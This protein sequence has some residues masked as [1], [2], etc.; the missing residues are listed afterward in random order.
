M[1]A[2][3]SM[4]NADPLATLDD[5]LARIAAGDSA[6]LAQMVAQHGDRLRGYIAN[7]LFALTSRAADPDD[8]DDA[9]SVMMED[10]WRK[11]ETYVDKPDISPVGLLF[12]FAR[13]SACKVIQRARR[14]RRREVPFDT[15]F[16]FPEHDARTAAADPEEWGGDV[17][18]VDLVARAVAQLPTEL[19]IAV[20]AVHINGWTVQQ[21]ARW[22]K[23]PEDRV[24]SRL[25]AGRAAIAERLQPY[26]YHW[27]HFDADGVSPDTV[28]ATAD[29]IMTAVMLY[30]GERPKATAED[31]R[32]HV[33]AHL[34]TRL[35]IQQM[36][37]NY[38]RRARAL[39][40]LA[41]AG[42]EAE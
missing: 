19:R 36:R 15:A 25:T 18:F 23:M 42:T 24:R 4:P 17:D 37:R 28:G 39:L 22:M 10:Y 31:V 8:I 2:F 26:R 14:R 11:A 16:P 33:A 38:V 30:L 6:P 5:A 41:S 35:N 20:S 3:A 7:V 29:D 34:G 9:F 40:Q 27:T 32:D 12:G 13:T 1:I 21:T